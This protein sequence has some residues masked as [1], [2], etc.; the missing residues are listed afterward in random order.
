MRLK[1]ANWLQTPASIRFWS[2]EVDPH[3]PQEAEIPSRGE[4]PTTRYTL[5]MPFGIPIRPSEAEIP[6]RGENPTT[7]YTLNMPFGIPIRSTRPQGGTRDDAWRCR[8]ECGLI[9][10]WTRR[11]GRWFGTDNFAVCARAG[12]YRYRGIAR[13]V[14]TAVLA[15]APN[16]HD[17]EGE[18]H[19]V[20]PPALQAKYM[21]AARSVG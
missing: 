17:D 10:T 4:N 3:G 20:D 14:G 21:W 7:R 9:R 12:I 8:T 6:S 5:N 13:L 18:S 1:D 15:L 19:V 16:E 2:P 11:H